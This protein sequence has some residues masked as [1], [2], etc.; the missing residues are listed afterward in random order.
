MNDTTTPEAVEPAAKAPASNQLKL[1]AN[2]RLLPRTDEERA[3]DAVRMREALRRIAEMPNDDPPGETE[4]I[5]RAIDS[6][7]PHRPLFEG[8]Y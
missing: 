2:G 8:Y 1:D 3:A 5:M 6:H 7:R 4:A